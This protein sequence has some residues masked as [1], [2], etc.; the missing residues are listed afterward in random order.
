MTSRSLALVRFVREL[1]RRRVFRMSGFYV[2]GAWLVMQAADVFFPGWG[3]PDTAINVLLGAAVFGFPLALVFGWFYDVTAHGIVRTPPLQEQVPAAPLP[4]RRTDYLLLGALAL[5][6]GVIA[7]DATREILESPLVSSTA[8]PETGFDAALPEKRPD[9]IAILPFDNMSNDPGNEVFCHGV[10]EEILNRLSLHSELKVIARTSSFQF[11][12]SAYGI[13]TIAAMLGVTNILQGSIRRQGDRIRISA[14]LVDDEGTQLWSQNY[15]RVLEDVFA[16]QDEIASLVAAAVVPQ[17]VP[18]YGPS[19]Q[20]SLVAYEHYLAGRDLLHRRDQLAAQKELQMAIDLDPGYA[21]AHA[22]YAISL[23]LR[24]P[25]EQRLQ[26]GARAIDTALELAPDLPRA[27]AARGLYFS[28]RSPP[29]ML[30]AETALREALRRDPN[31]VDAMN[32]LAGPLRSQGRD[33][34][35][36]EWQDRAYALD[37]FNSAVAVNMANRVWEKG[38]PQRAESMLRRLMELPDPPIDPITRLCELYGATGRLVEANEMAKRFLLAGGWLTYYPAYTY[39]ILGLFPSAEYW[40]SEMVRDRPDLVWVTSGWIQ[41]Q[42]P[43]WAGDYGQAAQR[44][45]QARDSNEISLTQLPL[46]LRFFYGINQSLAGD[47]AGAIETLVEAISRAGSESLDGWLYPVDA[48]QS[49]AWAY[50]HSGMPDK[51]RPLLDAVE[52]WFVQYRSTVELIDST[53]LHE[54]ARNAVLMDNQALALDRLEQAVASG[55]R[56]YYINNH[57]P[58]W[59]ALKDDPRYQALMAE[60]RADVDRQAAEVARIDAKEN[61][62]ALLKKVRERR[63]ATAD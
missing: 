51:A 48:H 54:L 26:E 52:Q 28:S 8:S 58:R 33:D 55:W 18:R 53:I 25:D 29:D 15:D 21:E 37:P 11:Q 12:A 22:E 24:L 16:I 20:P 59:G 39:A 63:E 47:F 42:V 6:A 13:P 2:V 46:E 19:Y 57:D 40:T 56:G 36:D 62:P 3:L 45:R 1:R 50:S 23:L 38:N 44:M 41:A 10:A 49:L 7:Y 43:Y 4:L 30:A 31:M 27:M 17:I 34:E 61:F 9:S 14:Q 35:A 60:V 5:I 32:W